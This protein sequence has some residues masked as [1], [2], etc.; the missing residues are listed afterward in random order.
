VLRGVLALVAAPGHEEQRR[1]SVHQRQ[2][3]ER[4]EAG[5]EP[6]V[7]HED[8]RAAPR[9]P[10]ASGEPDRDVLAHG[11][12][13]R[14]PRMRLERRDEVLDER[15]RVARGEVDPVLLEE[16]REPGSGD[17]HADTILWRWVPSPVI[18]IST[19]SPGCRYR[20]GFAPWPTPAGVPVEITSPAR[21]DMKR[22]T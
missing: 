4:V 9:E 3:G 19:T 7:L 12:H 16:I 22:L 5:A 6:R 17:A 13:V 8:R 1:Q 10:R 2:R 14:D 11:R 15:A 18:P 20:G 21:S